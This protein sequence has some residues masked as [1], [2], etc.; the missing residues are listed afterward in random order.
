M[1]GPH[2]SQNSAM[3]READQI[4]VNDEAVVVPLSYSSPRDLDLIKPWVKGLKYNAM[5][6][7]SLRDI[8]VEPH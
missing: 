2:G 5:S 8:V 3:Y 1:A 4:L 7:F 6:F